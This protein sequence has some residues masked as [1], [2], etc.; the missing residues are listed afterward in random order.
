MILCNYTIFVHFL[1]LIFF[2]ATLPGLF[3]L[4]CF[5]PFLCTNLLPFLL[6]YYLPPYLF[7]LFC[8]FFPPTKNSD[9]SLAFSPLLLIS[10][11]QLSI[12]YKLFFF[13]LCFI[14]S[15][16]AFNLYTIT[17]NYLMLELLIFQPHF[18][19]FIILYF[20]LL[21]H[22]FILHFLHH[23]IMFEHL[24]HK[25][26]R[27]FC[28]HS[29]FLQ[30]YQCFLYILDRYFVKLHFSLNVVIYVQFFHVYFLLTSDSHMIS[31]ADILFLAFVYK[32]MSLFLGHFGVQFVQTVDV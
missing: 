27:S 4:A 5:C 31:Y 14:F 2:L 12:A 18:L 3:Y 21:L 26:I 9:K 1:F 23:L 30:L 32:G 10:F 7:L 28:L 29:F 25:I 22:Q 16:F 13:S 6:S 24:G 17:Y 15:Y 19:L 11:F 8:W 20:H